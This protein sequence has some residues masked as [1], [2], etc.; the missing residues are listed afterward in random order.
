MSNLSLPR[1][2][3]SKRFSREGFSP[4]PGEQLDNMASNNDATIDIPLQQVQSDGGGFRREGS[5]TALNQQE[6]STSS[7]KRRFFARGRRKKPEARIQG[8]GKVGYDGEED[9]VNAMGKVY[10][11]IAN[12]SVVVSGGTMRASTKSMTDVVCRHGTSCTSSRWAY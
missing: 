7:E 10:R 12:F 3:Q 5:T 4:I 1:R 6:T 8:T 2:S 9:T 11:K